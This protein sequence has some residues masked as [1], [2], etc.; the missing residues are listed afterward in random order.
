MIDRAFIGKKYAAFT[1][2]LS[3]SFCRD[4][5]SRL[6]ITG[7][8]ESPP[9][10]PPLN[11]PGLMTLQGTA[12]L[13][14]LWEDLGVDPLEVRLVKE[15]FVHQRSVEC[16]EGFTGV[17]TIDDISGQVETDGR[18]E[19]QIELN[20][21]FKDSSGMPVATYQCSFRIPVAGPC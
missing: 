13:L 7:P 14:T 16:G 3:E 2:E 4:F 17:L 9:D 8:D 18:I 6:N 5:N 12:C 20:V 1:V 10:R 15:R 11:W 19:D 21:N